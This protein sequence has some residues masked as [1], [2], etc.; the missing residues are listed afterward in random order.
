MFALS[1][2][3]LTHNSERLLRQ[4]L[5]PLAEIADELIVLDSGS[6]DSTFA[7]CAE[8]GITPYSRPYTTH[9]EQMNVAISHASND[10]VLCMDS[11]EIMDA[12]SL[13]QIRELKAGTTPE[14]TQAFRISRYW[15]VL[16]QQ[17]HAI[18]PVSSPDF[19]VRLFNRQQA[20]FN[21][22]PVDDKPTGFKTTRI[23]GGHVRHDTFYSIHEVFTKLNGYTSRLIQYKEVKPSLGKAVLSSIG[24]FWKW[25]FRKGAW[26][27]GKV[28]V[29]TAV[30]AMMY[31]FL[32]YFKAWYLADEKKRR[33]DTAAKQAK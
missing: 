30:Y 21:D 4:V 1:V 32:K 8:F 16:G 10:W 20:R 5:A 12:D 31:S 18:Y 2:C 14:M 28:G 22:A 11:D 7:I 15:Y 13:Q 24:S 23:L 33:N 3:V 27:D 25:Y 19:P 17:V 9:A 26:K 6:T 29:V